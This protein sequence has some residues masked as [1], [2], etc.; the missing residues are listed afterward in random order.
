MEPGG[1]HHKDRGKKTP[2][3]VTL[4]PF[5]R[6]IRPVCDKWGKIPGRD[7]FL[8][9]PGRATMAATP[10]P[11]TRS[12]PRKRNLDEKGSLNGA[13]PLYGQAAAR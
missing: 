12:R 1:Y 11:F 5:P 10:Y 9:R 6:E 2:N 8:G 13:F 4:V 7:L 3:K